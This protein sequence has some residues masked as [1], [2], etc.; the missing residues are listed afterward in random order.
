VR[1]SV[2]AATLGCQSPRRPERETVPTLATRGGTECGAS[3]VEE[4]PRR[5]CDDGWLVASGRTNRGD[6]DARGLR[7]G[8]AVRASPIRLVDG[9]AI[10][11]YERAFERQLGVR[12]AYSFTSGRVGLYGLLRAMG[13]GRGDEVLQVPTHVVVPNA[14]RYTGAAPV[15]IDSRPDTFNMDLDQAEQRVTARTKVLLLQHTF[16][17]PVGI[18][19]ALAPARWHRLRVIEDCAHALGSTYDG[20]QVGSSATA[21]SSARK[22]RPSP[23]AWAGSS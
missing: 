5:R 4:R 1:R 19:R 3:A 21:R 6:D 10:A 8:R 13:V 2:V 17:I 7:D 22:R 14:I 20:R 16:G 11:R 23:A 15:F 18:D 12:Y 9:A